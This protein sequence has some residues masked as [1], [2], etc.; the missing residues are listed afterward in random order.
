MK[1]NE[2]YPG[3]S[4]S[5]GYPYTYVVSRERFPNRPTVNIG[6]TNDEGA[7]VRRVVVGVNPEVYPGV[8]D[9]NFKDFILNRLF[10][11]NESLRDCEQQ[12]TDL[13]SEAP[14]I[15]EEFGFE[16]VVGPKT[17]EDNPTKIYTSR[18]SPDIS[19]FRNMDEISEWVVLRKKGVDAFEEIK[20]NLRTHRIAYAAFYALGITIEEIENKTGS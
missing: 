18:F 8:D 15:P 16:K 9:S 2:D 14:F 7:E 11:Y 19:I 17:V 20:L 12:V 6:F 10:D 13:L 5:K 3:H 4:T 1:K